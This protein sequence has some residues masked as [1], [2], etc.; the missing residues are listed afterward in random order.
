M[1]SPA[2]DKADALTEQQ[3]VGPAARKTRLIDK[4]VERERGQ[5]IGNRINVRILFLID[6]FQ[7][8]FTVVTGFGA[9]GAVGPFQLVQRNTLVRAAG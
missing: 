2:T 7:I 1:P 9:H 4:N 5:V 3:Q 8:T 6:H